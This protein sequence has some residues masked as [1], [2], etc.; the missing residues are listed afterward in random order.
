MKT[1][2]MGSLAGIEAALKRAGC[3]PKPGYNG[4]GRA[5]CPVCGGTKLV[6]LADGLTGEPVVKC[7]NRRMRSGRIGE[8]DQGRIR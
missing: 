7:Q 4:A 8:S 6:Y 5:N 2:G 1:E 3:D